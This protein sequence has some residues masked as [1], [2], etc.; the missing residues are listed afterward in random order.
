VG[1]VVS[2]DGAVS[3]G[4]SVTAITGA[5]LGLGAVGGPGDDPRRLET[6][7]GADGSGLA[8]AM[9]VTT[10]AD[11]AGA[12]LPLDERATP[13]PIAT[14]TTAPPTPREIGLG[15]GR[16]AARATSPRDRDARKREAATGPFVVGVPGET[17]PTAAEANVRFTMVGGTVSRGAVEIGA[18][19]RS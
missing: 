15:R 2:N 14:A 11:D 17:G 8:G 5:A 18:P 12:L 1:F 10:A 13:T 9:V 3:F 16:R 7:L 6:A 19:C 4:R